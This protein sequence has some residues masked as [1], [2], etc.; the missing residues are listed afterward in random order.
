MGTEFGDIEKVF[1]YDKNGNMI[2]LTGISSP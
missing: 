1:C 2:Q